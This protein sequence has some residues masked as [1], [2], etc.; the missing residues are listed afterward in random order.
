MQNCDYFLRPVKGRI[1][2]DRRSIGCADQ[3][4]PG[5]PILF[6]NQAWYCFLNSAGDTPNCSLKALEK[7]LRLE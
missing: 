2:F 7:W 5:Q 6:L 3:S 4:A 1:C